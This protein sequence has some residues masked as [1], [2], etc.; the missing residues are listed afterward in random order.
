MQEIALTHTAAT[1]SLDVE[2]IFH[3]RA[4]PDAA[5]SAAEAPVSG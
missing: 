2:G 5:V 1:L 4:A 3:R